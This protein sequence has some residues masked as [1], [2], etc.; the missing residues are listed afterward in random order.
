LQK[1]GF[2]PEKFPFYVPLFG[3]SPQQ[4]LLLQDSLLTI[5]ADYLYGNESPITP[6]H[7]YKISLRTGALVPE[8]FRLIAPPPP[9]TLVC[10]L[11]GSAVS[12]ISKEANQLV[13]Q[14]KVLK[15]VYA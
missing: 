1:G 4:S 5:S 15:S 3:G 2:I 11:T 13:L 7:G 9:E 6:K 14:N 8:K 10:F 12:F